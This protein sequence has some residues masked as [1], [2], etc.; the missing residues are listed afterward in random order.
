MSGSS[1]LIW[2]VLVV[3]FTGGNV[4]ALAVGILLLVRPEHTTR[5]LG[6]RGNR[7][8]S[9]R[10]LTKSLEKSRDIDGPAMRYA[11][12]LGLLL[13]AGGICVLIRWS[14]FV[15]TTSSLDAARTLAQLFPGVVWPPLAWQWLWSALSITVFLG[16]LLAVAVGAL[17]FVRA[18]LLKRL[19]TLTNRWISTRRAAKPVSQPY[20]GIDRLVAL[21]PQ[22]WG[23]AL[24]L[25]SCY[26]LAMVV[27]FSRAL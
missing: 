7:P 14:G 22:V 4:L 27:W 23:A 24:A 10:R 6:L 20:Y 21:R 2:R 12:P 26:M 25:L 5:W 16:A 9:V 18:D 1:E 17:A 13:I 11:R 19:S 15:A 8:M 3:V